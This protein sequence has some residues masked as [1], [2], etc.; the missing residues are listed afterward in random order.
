MREMPCNNFWNVA[1][2]IRRRLPHIFLT[3]APPLMIC[4]KLDYG[5]PTLADTI[6][7]EER[8]FGSDFANDMDLNTPL[9]LRALSA[10]RAAWS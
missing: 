10:P 3:P 8:L 9:V 7:Q 4:D 2:D 1:Q 6:L 5:P